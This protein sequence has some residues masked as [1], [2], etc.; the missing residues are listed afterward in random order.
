MAESW[1]S[2]KHRVLVPQALGTDEFLRVT[3]HE[4]ERLVVFSHWSGA[5]CVAATP[6]RVS[7]VTELTELLVKTLAD[8]VSRT[9]PPAE[10]ATAAPQPDAELAATPPTWRARLKRLLRKPADPPDDP[11]LADVV[12]LWWDESA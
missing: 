4:P 1:G 12:P 9:Q 7:D 5:T 3:W 8:A 10:P 2:G 11:P 6:V